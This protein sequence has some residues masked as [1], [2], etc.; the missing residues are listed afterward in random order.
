M[1]ENR[2]NS[3]TKLQ[4]WLILS[5]CFNMDGRAAS[6]TIT[7][8][9]PYLME[10]GIKLHVL[11][12]V[13]GK[14]DNRFIHQQILGWGPSSLRFDFRHWFAN[15]FSRGFFYKIFTILISI[16]LS[17]LIVFEKIFLGYSS[18]WSWGISAYFSSLKLIKQ[19]KI[20]LI[21][22]TGGAWSAHLAAYWLKKK[23]KIKWIV[24][25]H[26][27]LVM[28]KNQ[29]DIGNQIPKKPDER[30]KY[31]L[32]KMICLNA[33]LVWWFTE[34]ALEF[35]KKR[36]PNLGTPGSAKAMIITP[37]ANPPNI[38]ELLASANY[39]YG[40]Y[41]NINH[42]GSLTNDR[43]LMD[44]L[45]IL[46]KFFNAYPQAKK[47][48]RF[49]IFGG[50]LD[51]NSRHW[52]SKSQYSENVIEY[53]RLEY[54]PVTGLTGREQI[55]VK[56]QKSDVLLLLHGSTEWCREY[57]PSKVY[58]YF[59]TNRP[60]WGLIYNNTQLHSLLTKRNSYISNVQDDQSIINSLKKI[61]FQ[62]HSQTLHFQNT[63]AISVKN[64]VDKILKEVL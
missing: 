3:S 17:P 13:T 8:K 47:Y 30:K 18:Q 48:I 19:G 59:W 53:G 22:S 37:G 57:I 63:P 24:E 61:Y 29:S 49:N 41:L 35:A 12:A 6:Q 36:N 31:W 46:S 51:K 39:K 21:Y 52:L 54:D 40:K 43:S 20:N 56:M 4:N 11:S 5:H 10:A 44:I 62:W 58:D 27:P 2:K 45:K 23:T 50:R 60:I 32:E 33:D 42:F 38:D 14:K 16:V 26:D 9:I 7:D 15:R 25:I 64:S 55:A 1:K 28:R 34:G